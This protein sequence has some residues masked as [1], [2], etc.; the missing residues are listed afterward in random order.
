MIITDVDEVQQAPETADEAPPVSLD[1]SRPDPTD[2]LSQWPAAT[3]STIANWFF[4]AVRSGTSDPAAI[5]A[6]VRTDLH[7]R[8]QWTSTSPQRQLLAQVA[9]A[10]QADPVAARTY[11][12]SVYPREQLPEAAKAALKHEKAKAF[13]LE[14]MKGKPA[15]DKQLALLRSL[16]HGGAVPNDRAEASMLIETLLRQTGG[17]HV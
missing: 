9:T 7:R 15:T 1:A 2:W 11:A 10:L 5:V 13:V 17:R 8:L 6:Q 14:A 12:A 16:G 3:R 4:T